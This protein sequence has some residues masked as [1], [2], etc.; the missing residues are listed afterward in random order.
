MRQFRIKNRR[1]QS[2]HAAVDSFHDVVAFTAV[3][4]ECYHPIGQPVVIG[5]GTSSIPVGAQVLS[6]VEGEGPDIAEGSYKLSLVA[7]EMRLGTVFYYPKVA[8]FGDGHD[9][10]HVRRLAVKVN[11]DYSNRRRRNLPFDIGRINGE[12]FGVRVRKDDSL[13][14]LRDGS[15]KLRSRN[16]PK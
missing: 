12:C 14:R 7:G 11:G 3:P 16:V 4:R 9:R 1:L 13:A 5:H 8:L 6:R 10:P 15:R 2:V